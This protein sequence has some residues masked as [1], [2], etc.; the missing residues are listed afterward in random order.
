MGKAG[1]KSLETERRARSCD[2]EAGGH[3]RGGKVRLV[4][5]RKVW[6]AVIRPGFDLNC[7]RDSW[8][9]LEPCRVNRASFHV[10]SERRL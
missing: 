3:Q 6:W 8:N 7:S 4:R 2:V 5:S 10:E 1:A 9:C